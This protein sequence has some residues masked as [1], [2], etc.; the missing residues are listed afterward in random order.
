M[1][2]R[3]NSNHPRWV[4][5]RYK[6]STQPGHHAPLGGRHPRSGPS[7]EEQQLLGQQPI[8]D[9]Y[10][11]ELKKRAPGRGVAKLKRLLTLKRT[12]PPAPFLAAIE[13]AA[14]YGLYDLN[15]LEALILKQVSGT[16]FDLDGI[17]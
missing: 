13:Q 3:R 12:Y 1:R 6:R 14:H 11:A 10:V 7:R 5:E 15:R 17:D 2:G 4:G 9:Q 8:L 16:Y